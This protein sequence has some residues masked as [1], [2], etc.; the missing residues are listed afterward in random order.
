MLTASGNWTTSQVAELT[1][2]T[3]PPVIAEVSVSAATLHILCTNGV[4]G[5]GCEVLATTNLALP[6]GDWPVLLSGQVGADGTFVFTNA[7]DQSWHRLFYRV[8]FAP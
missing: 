4:P 2:V 1:V 8:R 7:I 5:W 6:L 3:G